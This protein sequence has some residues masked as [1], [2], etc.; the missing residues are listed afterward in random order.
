MDQGAIVSQE[1]ERIKGRPRSSVMRS[2]KSCKS[3]LQQ[4]MFTIQQVG[5]WMEVE[6]MDEELERD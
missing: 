6:S 5:G 1:Q 3:E 2:Y 4:T